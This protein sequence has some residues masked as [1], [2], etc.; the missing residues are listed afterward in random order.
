ME[1]ISLPSKKE[2]EK[3]TKLAGHSGVPI[4]LDTWERKAGGLLE[5]RNL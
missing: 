4:V 1:T 3:E 2:K 5:P